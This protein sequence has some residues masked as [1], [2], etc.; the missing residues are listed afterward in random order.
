[1][2]TPNQWNEIVRP[3]YPQPRRCSRRGHGLPV[4][5]DGNDPGRTMR[6]SLLLGFEAVML[7]ASDGVIHRSQDHA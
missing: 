2:N 4:T 5:P 3:R 6:T 1:M 7:S